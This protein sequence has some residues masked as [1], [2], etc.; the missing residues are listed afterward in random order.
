MKE[1][2]WNRTVKLWLWGA[3]VGFSFGTFYGVAV[4]SDRVFKD[5]RYAGVVRIGEATFKCE[6]FSKVVLL[7]PDEVV[8]KDKKK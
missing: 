5:C 7:T 4:N 1:L 6:Q 2:I 8:T 3:F